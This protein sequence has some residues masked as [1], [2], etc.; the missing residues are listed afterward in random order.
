MAT[1]A[2]PEGAAVGDPAPSTSTASTPADDGG[3]CP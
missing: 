3:K 1:F 2:V